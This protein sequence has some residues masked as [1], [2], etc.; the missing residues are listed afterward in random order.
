MNR[1]I[2]WILSHPK[3]NIVIV[4]LFLLVSAYYGMSVRMDNSMEVWLPEHSP[5]MIQYQKFLKDFGSEE[6]ILIAFYM[7]EGLTREYILMTQRLALLLE[8]EK[9]VAK[10]WSLD[11]NF[12]RP[13]KNFELFKDVILN[14]SF[15]RSMLISKDGKVSA[16]IL[17]PSVEGVRNRI[18]LVEA[19][20]KLVADEVPPDIKVFIAGPPVINAELDR[21]SQE[22]SAIY[23]PMLFFVCLVLLLFFFR[24]ITG[25]AVPAFM[26]GSSMLITIGWMGIFNASLNII[27]VACF[28]LIMVISLAYSIYVY[29]AYQNSLI[30]QGDRVSSS[31]KQ[32]ALLISYRTVFLPV[33]LSAFTTAAGFGS[34]MV[35]NIT[36]VRN[37]GL[38]VSLGILSTFF[39]AMTFLP[40]MFFLLPSPAFSGNG[41]GG[42]KLLNGFIKYAGMFAIR[43]QK[44]TLF[45]AFLLF[46]L[47]VCGILRLSVETHILNFFKK[48][49]P[50]VR[51]YNF[52]EGSLT[53]LSPIEIVIESK[54]KFFKNGTFKPETLKKI[55]ELQKYLEQKKNVLSTHSAANI[56]S[57][58][59]RIGFLDMLF[60]SK[61]PML[62][63]LD[64]ALKDFINENSTATRVS[65]RAKTLASEKYSALIHDIDQY[66]AI[67]FR[68]ELRA[69]ITGVVPI[70]VNMQDC[71]LK[72]LI[73]SFCIAF[74]VICLVFFIFL[75]SVKN[76]IISMIPNIMPVIAILGF[77]GFFGINLD[78]A[79]V[80]IASIAMGIA[81]DDTIHFIFRYKREKTGSSDFVQ[82]VLA[83]LEATGKPI[84]HTSLITFCG[85]IVLCFSGFKPMI[86]F[87]LLTAVTVFAALTGDII[88]LPALL[89][90][91]KVKFDW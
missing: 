57:D 36:P 29:S 77:M 6:F 61:E 69:Y 59:T 23:S 3:G 86:Y 87:G 46:A 49:S 43:R 25:I 20:K 81:V 45:F 79:T 15:C 7:P 12:D 75:R 85:F 31:C 4:C 48:N 19:V 56:I 88:V 40:S 60:V 17:V 65:V 82:P 91:F 37:L 55:K 28:P 47:S 52:I 32:R 27:T 11:R 33:F 21:M 24:S 64:A 50:I 83:T 62:S 53:G 44:T 80:M 73:K 42:D 71:L 5:A 13:L 18:D 76:T 39:L 14:S 58:R 8:R 10:A 51:A 9:G 70:I 41:G 84:F 67:H 66:L 30:Q 22:V 26:M 16:I 74:G 34:L 72:N 68:D 89:V 38:F 78:V 54:K 35:S 63:G 1:F 2:A 90:R